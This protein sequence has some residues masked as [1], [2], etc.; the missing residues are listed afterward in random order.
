MRWNRPARPP[1]PLPGSEL[2]AM[3]MQAM[4]DVFS[5]PSLHPAAA[6]TAT[7]P[8]P[9][10]SQLV[11]TS[12][13]VWCEVG[14]RNAEQQPPVCPSDS[15]MMS[16]EAVIGRGVLQLAIGVRAAATLLAGGAPGA[17]VML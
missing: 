10:P 8:P 4:M 14:L 5:G 13:A 15:I 6:C 12:M 3:L 1:H 17:S 7:P 2:A 16:G 11:D 9:P